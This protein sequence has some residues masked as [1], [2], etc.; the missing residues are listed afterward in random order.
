MASEQ[1]DLPIGVTPAE[2]RSGGENRPK[3][4]LRM[5]F[6]RAVAGM[7]F[8]AAL[9]ALIVLA[10][11]SEILTHRITH[12]EHR[13]S[14]MN[15]TVQQLR[16]RVSSAERR[17]VTAVERASADETLKRVV[18]ASDLRTIKLNNA[19]TLKVDDKAPPS[20]T[21]AI[22]NSQNA[23]VLQIAGVAV[24]AKGNVYRV[25]WQEKHRPEALAA[26][27]IPDAD[28]KATVP[29]QLPPRNAS[30]VM[31]TCEP[32]TDIAKPSGM[33]ILKGKIAP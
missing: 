33:P 1:V 31:V 3:W 10:E 8:A 16:R 17:T 5:G 30:V 25:W 29:M 12:Y 7:A 11:F 9:A 6:W 15:E 4:Y 22:S 32:G 14:A 26:E 27:F 21:L 23:A 28:G 13:I 20:G 24:A 2:P 18:S 19:G